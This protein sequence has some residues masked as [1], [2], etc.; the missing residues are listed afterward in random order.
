MLQAFHKLGCNMSLNV[1][2]LFNHLHYFLNIH[3][4]SISEEQEEG[5]HQDIQEMER[6][7]QGGWNTNMLA[8]YCWTLKRDLPL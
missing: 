6:R 8:D 7:Y 3:L 5:F 4:G 2:F 1:H